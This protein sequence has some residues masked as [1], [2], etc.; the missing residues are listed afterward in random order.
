MERDVIFIAK[1][2]FNKYSLNFIFIKGKYF[3]VIQI[4]VTHHGVFK[5]LRGENNMCS[6]CMLN[7]VICK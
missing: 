6:I 2:L 5:I 1:L 7:I 4:W 3:E